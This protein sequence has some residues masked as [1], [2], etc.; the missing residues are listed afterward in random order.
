MICAIFSVDQLGGIG[1]QGTLPWS[2]HPEDMQWFR[3]LTL[4]QVVV[5]GRR[6]WDDPKMLKPL[7]DRKNLVFSHRRLAHTG[8]ELI[9]GDVC[10]QLQHLEKRHSYQKICVIGGADL[11][12]QAKPVLD[13]VYVT[14]RKGATRCDTRMDMLDFFVGM[15]AISA[16][17]SEDKML[18]FSIY[19]N[20]YSKVPLYEGL[21]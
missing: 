2:H 9:G 18:N 1:N 11:I 7:P 19:R 20:I 13:F 16:R 8:A 12:R 14:H 21:P 10:E 15:R 6:T 17:P 3:D 4:K 5:M